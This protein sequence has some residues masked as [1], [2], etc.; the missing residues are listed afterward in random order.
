MDLLLLRS[1]LAVADHKAVT[2]AARALGVT[3]PA[4]SRR[5]QQL[6]EELGATLLVRSKQGAVLTEAGRIVVEEA[7]QLA[8]RYGRL[9][10]RVLASQRLE[11]GLV[12]LGGG[13][14]A[15][16]FLVPRAIAQ[17]E[18]QYPG[19]RFEVRE[20]GSRDVEADVQSER[21]E[22]GIVTL[23]THSREF[24]VRPLVRDRIVLVAA[25]GHPLAKRR[26]VELADLA[27]QGLV[28]FERGSAIRQL[29]DGALEAAGVTMNVLM[30]LRSVAAILEMVA[31]TNLLAFVSHLGVEGRATGV[32]AIAVRGLH[33]QRRLAVISKLGRP[34]SPAAEAFAAM[35]R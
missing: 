32:R 21:L 33:L 6:E 29:I 13:A 5:L 24:V 23:P 35:L 4:L 1:L 15:V 30:E 16:S 8:E 22:L 18:K 20:E 17:F 7:R 9:R 19:V 31:N 28:G 12:R 11:A 27:G 25:P 26:K 34:L 3:Q 2:K 10:E 14:T